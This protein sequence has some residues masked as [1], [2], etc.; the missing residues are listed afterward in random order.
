M[1]P[2]YY[3]I[4]LIITLY[5]ISFVLIDHVSQLN[6]EEDICIIKFYSW[7][8]LHLKSLVVNEK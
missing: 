7:T 5:T 1:I 2:C 3:D 4:L 8:L 6:K